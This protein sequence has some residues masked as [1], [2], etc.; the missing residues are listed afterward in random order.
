[1]RRFLRASLKTSAAVSFN[2][3]AEVFF[4]PILKDAAV[5]IARIVVR[6]KKS[7]YGPCIGAEK[8]EQ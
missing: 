7:R 4:C 5:D 6:G 3:E 8:T 2:S 1:V